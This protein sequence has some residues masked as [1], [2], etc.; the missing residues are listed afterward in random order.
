MSQIKITPKHTGINNVNELFNLLN[1]CFI[2][3]R[4]MIYSTVQKSYSTLDKNTII[5]ILNKCN[6][7][8]KQRPGTVSPEQYYELSKYLSQR[9]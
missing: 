6:I 4:K 7:S 8:S 9:K 5:D 3:R 2:Q 1:N